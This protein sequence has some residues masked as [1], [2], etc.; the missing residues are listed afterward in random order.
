[1]DGTLMA[2]LYIHRNQYIVSPPGIWSFIIGD[3]YR[4]S[5]AFCEC[6]I[7]LGAAGYLNSH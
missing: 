5:D 1:M 7:E 6:Y 2:K 3:G 4:Q